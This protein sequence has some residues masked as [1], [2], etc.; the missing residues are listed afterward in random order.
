MVQEQQEII[1]FIEVILMLTRR[2]DPG[3]ADIDQLVGLR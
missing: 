3:R 2:I 1:N